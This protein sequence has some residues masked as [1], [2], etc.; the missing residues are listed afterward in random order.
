MVYFSFAVTFTDVLFISNKDISCST[1]SFSCIVHDYCLTFSD[2]ISKNSS[3]FLGRQ[4]A[5]HLASRSPLLES[6]WRFNSEFFLGIGLEL[7]K[8]VTPIP[9]F[10]S[11]FTPEKWWLEDDPFLLGR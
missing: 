6:A 2:P 5:I 1:P 3:D 9:K 8:F 11:E 7:Q 4:E 10:N